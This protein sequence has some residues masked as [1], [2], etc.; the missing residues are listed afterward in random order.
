MIV[1]DAAKCKQRWESLRSQYRKFMRNQKSKVGDNG[2]QPSKWKYS[3][4]LLFLYPHMKDKKR[5]SSAEGSED[6]QEEPEETLQAES[7]EPCWLEPSVG[8][9]FSPPSQKRG[10]AEEQQLSA[11]EYH[12]IW[13]SGDQGA[14]R[15]SALAEMASS[16]LMKHFMDE[17][18]KEKRVIDEIDLF[19]D[20]MKMT[21]KKFSVSDRLS[22]K[23]KVF[24]IVAEIEEK[25]YAGEQQPPL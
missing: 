4:Q 9:D 8:L 22:V 7:N 17:E 13:K 14:K 1:S 25:K 24:N 2:G 20:T 23:R 21:V 19:F 5:M 10:A 12:G 16:T 18:K 15:Q 11:N 6:A 3:D